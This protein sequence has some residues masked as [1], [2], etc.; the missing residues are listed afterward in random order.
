MPLSYHIA[1]VS[2]YMHIPEINAL[3][4]ADICVDDL[5]VQVLALL[6]REQ[7]NPIIPITYLDWEP[8]CA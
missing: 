4:F 5:E 8:V 2:I 1:F 7:N 6:E 3:L